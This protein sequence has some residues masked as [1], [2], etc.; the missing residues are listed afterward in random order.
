MRRSIMRLLSILL[1]VAFT[2]TGFAYAN[3]SV[4][5]VQAPKVSQLFVDVFT[6]VFEDQNQIYRIVS[7]NGEDITEVFFQ[8]TRDLY[9]NGKWQE[10]KVYVESHVKRVCKDEPEIVRLLP[11]GRSRYEHRTV[12]ESVPYEILIEDN[13]QVRVEVGYKLIGEY[14]YDTQLNTINSVYPPEFVWTVNGFELQ[15]FYNYDVIYLQRE[16]R[17]NVYSN[18]A[19]FELR[20]EFRPNAGIEDQIPVEFHFGAYYRMLREHI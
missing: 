11:E 8:E 3:E 15:G 17:T 18:E 2:T 7:V 5:E 16:G 13:Q 20:W 10:L 9:E 1:V 4:K 6:N 12:V 14:I 19:I